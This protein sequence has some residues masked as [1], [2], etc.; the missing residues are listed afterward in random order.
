ME[1]APG[2]DQVALVTGAAQGIGRA[3]A[4]LLA[5]RGFRVAVN[6]RVATDELAE[7]ASQATGVS[8]PAD[9]TDGEAMRRAVEMTERELGPVTLLVANAAVMSIGSFAER[10]PTEWNRQIEVNLSGVFHCVSAVVPGMISRGH[11]R[12][13][14]V[15]S[16]WGVTGIPRATAYSASK[17]G[18]ISLVKSLAHELAPSGVFVNA[19]APGAVDTPQLTVDARSAGLSPE[20]FKSAVAATIPARRVLRPEEIAET[21]G[22][23]ASREADAFVGQVIQPN[24]GTTTCSF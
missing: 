23:L 5:E 7:V 12:I 10:D 21:V 24:G 15:A 4:V 2:R 9:V 17:A 18:L 1:T 6:D 13:I 22:F 14:A 19:I 11:G 20:E 3:T 8:V 16:R